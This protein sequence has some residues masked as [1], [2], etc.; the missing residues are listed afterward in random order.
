MKSDKYV[1]NARGEPV[2]EPDL[3]TWAS[4]FENSIDLRRVAKTCVS[5]RVEVSTVFLAI[6]HNFSLDGP[7]VLWETMI[8]GGKHNYEMWRYISREDA[9]KGHHAAVLLAKE[10]E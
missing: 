9:I 6:D 7:P 10:E 4:W 8:F 5:P 2:P 1:L 3:L